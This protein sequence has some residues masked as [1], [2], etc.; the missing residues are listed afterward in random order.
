MFLVLFLFDHPGDLNISQDFWNNA[1]LDQQ[2]RCIA[3]HVVKAK[4]NISVHTLH[5]NCQQANIDL[6]V[7]SCFEATGPGQLAVSDATMN[8]S[9]SGSIQESNV[10]PFV[11]QLKNQGVEI[12]EP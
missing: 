6:L 12:S 10:R 11:Q 9:I 4:H 3:P 7:W 1:K 8:S 5:A 2:D